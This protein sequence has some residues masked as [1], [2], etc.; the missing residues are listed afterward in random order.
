MTT[1]DD[2]V[3]VRRA[4]QDDLHAAAGL[5]WRWIVGERGSA[6]LDDAEGFAASLVAWADQHADTHLCLVAVDGAHGTEQVVGL[7]W[8]ALQER[9]PTPSLP[10]RLTGDVQSVYVA[11]EHRGAGVARRLVD[12]LLAE[13]WALGLERVTVHSD[14]G[15]VRL[16]ERAGFAATPSLLEI[17]RP[18]P[19][20]D[21]AD[22]VPDLDA[23]AP[24]PDEEHRP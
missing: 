3:S 15:A 9:V 16:Y 18:D 1:S 6:P 11:P 21:R 19:A 10:R 17:D 4:E 23:P 7:A 12:A 13:A 5:R 24:T 22:P 2:T 20:R 8:L 14:P